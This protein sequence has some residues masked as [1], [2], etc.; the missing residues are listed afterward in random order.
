ML[1]VD[2]LLENVWKF[3]GQNLVLQRLSKDIVKKYKTCV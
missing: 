3:L 2:N 1:E